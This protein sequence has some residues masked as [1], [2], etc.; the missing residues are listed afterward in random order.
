MPKTWACP[1][2]SWE[3][4]LKVHCEGGNLVFPCMDSRVLFI[5][6][7]CACVPGWNNCCI[8]QNL[9]AHYENTHAKPAAQAAPLSF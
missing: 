1:F 3:E 8:A 9:L 7:F 6:Q 4:K 5:D 2:W